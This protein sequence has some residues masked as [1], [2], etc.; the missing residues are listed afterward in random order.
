MGTIL[1]QIVDEASAYADDYVT[2]EIVDVVTAGTLVNT[3]EVVQFKVKVSN[4]GP[5]HMERVTV[6]LEGRNGAQVRAQ[7]SFEDSSESDV[8]PTIEAHDPSGDRG[9]VLDGPSNCW[10]RATLRTR[11]TSS[12]RH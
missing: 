4:A 2:L 10:R 9:R 3:S 1:D 11:R 8:Y 7:G 12:R 5:M 6:L